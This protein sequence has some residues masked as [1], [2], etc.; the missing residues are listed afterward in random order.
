MATENTNNLTSEPIILAESIS[1]VCDVQAFVEENNNTCYFYLWFFPGKEQAYI[2]SCWICNTSKAPTQ[3]DKETMEQGYAPALEARYIKHDI[4]GIHLQK[5]ALSIVWFEEG[6][7]AALLENGSLLCVIPGWS[8]MMVENNFSGYAKYALGATPFAW[9]LEAAEPVLCARIE[10]CMAFWDYFEQDYWVNVQQ[11]HLQT[12]EAFFGS[13]Q[14]YFA[15]DGGDFPPKALVTGKKNGICYAFTAGVS[16]IPMPIVEQY[17]E[18]EQAHEFRRIE[19][20]FAAMEEYE[21]I[22]M[23]MYSYLSALSSLPWNEISFLGHG[24]TIPCNAIEGYGAV[25]LLNTRLLPEIDAPSYGTFMYDSINMLWVI[26]I[27]KPEY[28]LLR[29]V[30]VEDA[31]SRIAC[32]LSHL[33]VFD[34]SLRLF[35]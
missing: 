32:P 19:L 34:G 3:L 1:P 31:L 12:L 27:T 15:I 16:L 22:C 14:R 35:L 33:P 23:Q 10:R 4:N 5:D 25:W 30:S 28:D 8:G 29:T 13:Y 9:E 24:H 18:G 20:G 6:D 7:A 17:Y 26:P 2:K 21:G 11:I